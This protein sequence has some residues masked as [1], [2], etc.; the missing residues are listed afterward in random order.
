MGIAG[1][2]LLAG[3]MVGPDYTPPAI[4]APR[5]FL[6][7][8]QPSTTS[9][10][11]TQ[12]LAS[13]PVDLTR[14][15]ETFHD[16]VLNQLI[17][18]AIMSNLDIRLADARV[19]EARAS[20]SQDVGALFPTLDANG[21]YSRS[22]NSSNLINTNNQNASQVANNEAAILS[23]LTGGTH[24][25]YQ[26]GFDAGWEIDVFGGTR[27][28][29]EAAQASLQ[30]LVDARRDA[31]ITLLSEVAR[32]YLILR[33]AQHERAAVLDNIAAEKDTLELMSSKFQAGIATDLDVN[34]QQ[35][36]V[37]SSESQLPSLE[38]EI[39]QS[40]HRLGVLLNLEPEALESLLQP[41]APLAT[42]PA[43]VPPGLPSDLLLRRP[44]VKQAERNM[45]EAS[46]TIGVAV[47]ELFPKFSLTGSFGLESDKLK[48]FT[49]GSS[50]FFSFGPSVSWRAFDAGQ[51]LANVQVE[52]ARFEQAKIQYR[53][54][55]LQ[56]L[57]EVEDAIVAYT[58][59]QTRRDALQRSVDADIRA[60]SEAK[61]LNQ[62]GVVDFLNV[63][64]AQQSLFIAQ[65]QL[66]QSQ[67]M[68]STDLVALFKS[69][70]GGWDVNEPKPTA[71]G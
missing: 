44:D 35:A 16:P 15:W 18:E 45:A 68:V 52:K 28:Q 29:I 39:Q 67:Q 53:Q 49:R 38:T 33:G 4:E 41:A 65:V 27:R 24:D 22:R 36:Q 12:A 62:A 25:L 11:A 34:Q 10:A 50:D 66:A 37:A 40:I 30:G 63:L 26:A 47:A 61:H 58:Q 54:T 51:L 42:G 32:N 13:A 56:A 21:S 70:G 7:S 1:S 20:L 6:A 43:S 46:A 23:G 3:C 5:K 55:V 64:T 59:E 57:Q 2:A 8:T 14:W 60:V 69:L 48:T 71:K 9:P 19:L 17:D 31:T